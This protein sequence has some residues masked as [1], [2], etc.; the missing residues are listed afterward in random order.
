M[1]DESKALQELEDMFAAA[2]ADPPA[3]PLHL[4]TAILADAARVQPGGQ[5]AANVRAERQPMWRQLIEAVGG[6]PALG[7]LTAACAAGLWIGMAPPSFVPDPAA[8]AGYEENGTAVPYD[9]YDM[10]MV[11]SE[12]LQ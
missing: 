10:A 4:N 7:G 3:L 12:D 5:T 1:A 2:R 8:L 11:L 9:S 6:W